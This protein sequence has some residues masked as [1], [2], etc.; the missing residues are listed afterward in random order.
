[1][2]FAWLDEH[3]SIYFY[4]T[5]FIPGHHPQMAVKKKTSNYSVA[6]NIDGG[7]ASINMSND[8]NGE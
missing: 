3:D 6:R 4:S 7:D 5:Q 2:R 8:V 1:M